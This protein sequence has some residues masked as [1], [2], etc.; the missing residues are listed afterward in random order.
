MK[1][2][3]RETVRYYSA[4]T[5]AQLIPDIQA[6]QARTGSTLQALREAGTAETSGEVLAQIYE[7]MFYRERLGVA[8]PAILDVIMAQLRRREQAAPGPGGA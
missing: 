1:C 7:A 5:L 2:N 6:D 3:A 8:L 4:R